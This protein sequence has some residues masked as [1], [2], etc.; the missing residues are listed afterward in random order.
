MSLE[1]EWDDRK[2][3]SNNTKHGVTFEDASTIF[4]DPNSLTIPDPAH[5]VAEDRFVTIGLAATMRLLVVVH[6]DRGD[7][8]RLI[9]ARRA[10]RKEREN[11]ATGI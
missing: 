7:R 9:S 5:S 3:T 2:A 11:Y 6:T 10:S 4:V 1:F 8:L